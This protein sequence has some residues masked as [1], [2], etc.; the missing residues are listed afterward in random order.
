M[1]RQPLYKPEDRV[2]DKLN[3]GK[4]FSVTGFDPVWS[5]F[6][7][8]EKDLPFYYC[9]SDGQTNLRSVEEWRLE[10]VLPQKRDKMEGYSVSREHVL[11]QLGDPATWKADRERYEKDYHTPFPDARPVKDD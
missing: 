7:S 3:P 2:T 9:L 6:A 4:T 11:Q 10:L 8:R 5:T 1:P